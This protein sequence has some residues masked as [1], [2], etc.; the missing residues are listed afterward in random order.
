M[1][2]RSS[3]RYGGLLLAL[4]GIALVGVAYATGGGDAEAPMSADTTSSL[5]QIVLGDDSGAAPSPT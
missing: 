3:L 1:T 4:L 5:D 2:L